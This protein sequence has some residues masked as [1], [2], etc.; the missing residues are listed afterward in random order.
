MEILELL[1]EVRPDADFETSNEFI[2]DGLLD[3]FDV[4]VLV[5]LIEEKYD[6]EICHEFLIPENFETI[7]SICELVKKCLS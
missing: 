6:I 2:E 5:N 1:K 7:D 4:I 3:S